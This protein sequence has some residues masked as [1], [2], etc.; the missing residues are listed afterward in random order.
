MTSMIRHAAPSHVEALATLAALTFPLACPPGHTPENIA[1]HIRQV[2]SAERFLEYVTSEDF[3]L[4]VASDDDRL[5][6]YTLADYRASNDPDV[7]SHLSN[8]GAYAELSKL[9]VHPDFHG[10]GIAQGLR[11]KALADMALRKMDTA[12]LTV[13]QLNDRANSFYEKSG[14]TV[15]AE[16]KYRVGNVVDDDYLRVRKLNRG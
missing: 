16:K 10:A 8:A 12:W 2:L 6:G 4:S 9:Y 15:I 3:D 1:D 5:M 7:R 11:D 13:N 14:F